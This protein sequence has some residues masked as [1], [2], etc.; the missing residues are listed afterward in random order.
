MFTKAQ[1]APKSAHHSRACASVEAAAEVAELKSVALNHGELKL[2]KWE[3]V[4]G[5]D[6]RCQYL[7]TFGELLRRRW[8]RATCA[9][10]SNDVSEVIYAQS[11]A[12]ELIQKFFEGRSLTEGGKRMR[13]L[14]EL[15]TRPN[16]NADAYITSFCESKDLLSQWRAYG[17]SAG[18]EIR[19]L[20]LTALVLHS[21]AM[22]STVLTRVEYEKEVQQG[23][24][25]S[26]FRGALELLDEPESSGTS[27]EDFFTV[28]SALSSLLMKRWL[29]SIKHPSFAEEKEW[30]IIAFPLLQSPLAGNQYER[31]EAIKFRAGR[32]SLV[33]Y[34]E[35]RPDQGKLPISD[36]I[37]GPGGNHILTAKA[38]ELLLAAQHFT[39]V[40]V[41]NSQVPLAL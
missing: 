41:R 10:Y 2:I 25:E 34:V 28:V 32:H 4:A 15:D 17:K 30:R 6:G 19:F 8:R 38:V 37:C 16:T 5:I 22:T 18:F 29:Y 33:P 1:M 9:Q 12:R 31:P 35:L 39:N 36:I 24:L 23:T 21:P 7:S 14:W 27:P 20:G 26:L 40:R 11:V 3:N 13:A